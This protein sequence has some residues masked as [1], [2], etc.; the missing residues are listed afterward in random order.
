MLRGCNVQA[1]LDSMIKIE[2]ERV[3]QV[4]RALPAYVPAEEIPDE[5][6]IARTEAPT[7][8]TKLTL[9]ITLTMPDGTNLEG[10]FSI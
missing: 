4:L 10:V 5:I 7:T 3:R 2:E 1:S 6:L 9:T 8:D